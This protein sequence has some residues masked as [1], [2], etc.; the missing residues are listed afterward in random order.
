[1]GDLALLLGLGT[2]LAEPGLWS[3][4]DQGSEAGEG[5]AHFA[6]NSILSKAT[7]DHAQSS[8]QGHR[9]GG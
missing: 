2:A 9:V 3:G 7:V 5:Q 6:E 1:M 8:H 4:R